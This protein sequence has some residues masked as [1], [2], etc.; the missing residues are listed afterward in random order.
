MKYLFLAVLLSVSGANANEYFYKT[1]IKTFDKHIEVE[2]RNA[3]VYL[4]KLKQSEAHPSDIV[5][6]ISIETTKNSCSVK[7]EEKSENSHSVKI[8]SEKKFFSKGMDLCKSIIS[9][10]MS[11]L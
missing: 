3:G 2:A 7:M 8:R 1:N 10:M 4:K 5:L 9:K 6:D 11:E